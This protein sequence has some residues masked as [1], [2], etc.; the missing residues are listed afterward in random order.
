MSGYTGM[1]TDFMG[2]HQTNLDLSV[3]HGMKRTDEKD[4]CDY[5][6]HLTGQQETEVA[7]VTSNGCN[8]HSE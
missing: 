5:H 8:L 2:Q 6:F 7:C 1:Y 4:S 3:S